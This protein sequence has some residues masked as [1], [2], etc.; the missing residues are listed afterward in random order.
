MIRRQLKPVFTSSTKQKGALTNELTT[1]GHYQQK[2]FSDR[3]YKSA[4]H[5]CCFSFLPS[6]FIYPPNLCVGSDAPQRFVRDKRSPAC[7]FLYGA[8]K[9]SRRH[10]SQDPN[11]SAPKSG[12]GFLKLSTRGSS[13]VASDFRSDLRWSSY[14][15]SKWGYPPPPRGDPV[16]L[17]GNPVHP[18]PPPLLPPGTT[19]HGVPL[20]TVH[21]CRCHACS[22]E[23]PGVP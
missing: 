10:L 21:A 1:V 23:L 17:Q 18:R 8:A 2:A 15:R 5:I 16:Q 19:L 7:Y 13:L 9:K 11:F 3:Y 22:I 6:P 12:V 20:A 4:R 14:W